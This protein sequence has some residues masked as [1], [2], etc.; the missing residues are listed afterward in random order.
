MERTFNKWL[1]MA[2]VIIQMYLQI[3]KMSAI[4]LN[5]FIVL[6]VVLVLSPGVSAK[7]VIGWVENAGVSSTNAI[8]KAKIDTGADSSSLHCDC[9][10]P[11]ENDGELWV[12]FTI[13]DVDGQPFSYEKKI[14][15]KIRVKRHFGDVQ[16]RYVVRMGI[17]IGDR[18]EETDVSLVDRSGFNY[19]LLIGRKYLKDRF[20]VDPG[21]TFITQPQCEIE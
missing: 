20:I 3:N 10:T 13:T 4:F 7:A 8:I 21:K 19:D 17:C 12:R 14:I 18:Y 11:Y 9:I 16:H 6:I 15:R 5:S 2:Q 1:F